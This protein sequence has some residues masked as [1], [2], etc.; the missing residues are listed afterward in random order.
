MSYNLKV[1][2]EA[3]QHIVVQVLKEDL[4]SLRMDWVKVYGSEEGYVFNKDKRA[5]L[6]EICEHISAFKKLI[7]YYGNDPFGD[8]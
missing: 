6:E 8:A 5:D 2:W 4:D 3:I 1:D 7:R